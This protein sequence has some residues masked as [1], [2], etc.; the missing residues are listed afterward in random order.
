MARQSPQHPSHAPVS[1]G[2]HQPAYSEQPECA[3]QAAG[4]VLERW[5]LPSDLS[6]D[7]RS[8]DLPDL[9]FNDPT[10]LPWDTSSDKTSDLF[11]D[12]LVVLSP[13]A[14]LEQHPK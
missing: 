14:L 8:D 2:Q 1:V 11:T 10:D 5:D 13:S 9:R 12:L 7:Q 4:L 3:E 6:S